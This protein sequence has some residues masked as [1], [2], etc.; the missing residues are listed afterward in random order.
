MSTSLKCF[1]SYSHKNTRDMESV[2]E[3]LWSINGVLVDHD[4]DLLIGG[5]P[6]HDRL[7]G[8]LRA[9]DCVIAL[10]SDEALRSTEVLDE[11]SRAHEW[12]RCIVPVV[13]SNVSMERMPWFLRDVHQIRQREGSAF[14]VVLSDLK[15]TIWT[16]LERSTASP[17]EGLTIVE[18]PSL[19]RAMSADN[20]GKWICAFRESDAQIPISVPLEATIDRVAEYLVQSLLPHLLEERYVWTLEHEGRE[21]SPLHTVRTSGVPKDGVVY[22]IGKRTGIVRPIL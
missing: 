20:C 14:E 11:L 19:D 3:L 4:A 7:H 9:S 15:A 1:V 10:L 6:V 22:L 8:A 18:I 16:L 5:D 2:V 13:Y 21:L 12:E 17:K